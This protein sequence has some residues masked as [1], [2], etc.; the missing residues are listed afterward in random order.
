MTTRC[1]AGGTLAAGAPAVAADEVGAGST[2]V[3]KDEALDSD[4]SDRFR[5]GLAFLQDRGL[6][7]LD[8]TQGLLFSRPAK[9]AGRVGARSRSGRLAGR[10]GSGNAGHGIGASARGRGEPRA[11]GADQSGR[12][13]VPHSGEVG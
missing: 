9:L 8:R 11:T 1:R 13:R 5:P 7:L 2:L 10:G 3:E 12:D 4:P 6:V